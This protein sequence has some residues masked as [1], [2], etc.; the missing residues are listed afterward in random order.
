MA[1][2]GRAN[3][4]WLA[5]QKINRLPAD[6]FGFGHIPGFVVGDQHAFVRGL[7]AAAGIEC[8]LS[9][10][11]TVALYHAGYAGRELAQI[12]IIQE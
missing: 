5:V 3:R 2:D 9:K 7:S 1:G 8:A 6:T 4:G 12:G 11:D 10:Y